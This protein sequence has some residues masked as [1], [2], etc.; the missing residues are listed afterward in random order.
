MINGVVILLSYW[1]ANVW[2][3]TPG[4]PVS[5]VAAMARFFDRQSIQGFPTWN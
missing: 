2:M 1:E 4:R 5:A 3:R